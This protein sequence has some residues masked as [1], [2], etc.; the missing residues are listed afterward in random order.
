MLSRCCA[1]ETHN[2][3]NALKKSFEVSKKLYHTK[4][5]K[6]SGE[7]HTRYLQTHN[8]HVADRPGKKEVSSHQLLGDQTFHTLL[9]L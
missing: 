3:F 5:V 8:A 4:L 9:L 6:V 7:A 2:V 1:F